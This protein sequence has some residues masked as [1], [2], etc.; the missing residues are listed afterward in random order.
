MGEPSE[1]RALVDAAGVAGAPP[2]AGL[3]LLELPTKLVTG[4]TAGWWLSVYPDAREAGG[5]W[6]SSSRRGEPRFYPDDGD[7][8]AAA[9]RAERSKLEAARRARGKVRRYCAAHRLNRLG[10]LT[11]RGEGCHDPKVLRAD[12]ARF[13]KALRRGMGGDPFPYLW[14][15]EWHPGG[16]GLHVHFVVARFV[17]RRLIEAA[18][19]HGFVHIKLMGNLPVG[20][21]VMAEARKAARYLSKYVSKD[22]AAGSGLH[23][24]EVAQGFRPTV[25][26]IWG[27]SAV[28]AIVQASVFIG[29]RPEYIWTSAQSKDWAGPP[30]A[31]VSWP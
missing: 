13:F 25:T 11:Y 24:Y 30:A 1:G 23:R 7:E 29:L 16:H 21:G 22:P 14:V 15:P 26:K 8:E 2:Q 31:W 10:T 28:Q 19:P 6:V 27:L 17:P 18:W 3:S 9:S 20:S 4:Q 12:V 5:C